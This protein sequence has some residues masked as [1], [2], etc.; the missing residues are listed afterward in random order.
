MGVRFEQ[1]ACIC[2]SNSRLDIY[3]YTVPYL[4]HEHEP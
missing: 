1:Q 4:L 3:V 2:A